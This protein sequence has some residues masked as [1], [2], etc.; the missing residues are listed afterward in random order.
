MDG[1]G[2]RW[3]WNPQT[4]RWTRWVLMSC[5]FCNRAFD[6]DGVAPVVCGDCHRR[7]VEEGRPWL[8]GERDRTGG[9]PYNP[10]AEGII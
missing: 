8:P 9:K 4:S 1:G 5:V 7:I 10:V 3:G 2:E 6:W